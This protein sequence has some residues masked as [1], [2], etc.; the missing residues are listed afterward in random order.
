V[1]EI[2]FTVKDP[3]GLH[4]RPAGNFVKLAQGF[5]SEGTL[6]LERS[7]KSASIKRLLAVM[8]LGVKGGD[9]ICILLKGEDEETAAHAIQAWLEENLG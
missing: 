4:A 2:G 7:E 8:S 5:Q 3:H 9:R 6:T 1:K